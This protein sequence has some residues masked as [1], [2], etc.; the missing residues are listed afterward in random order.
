MKKP[1]INHKTAQIIEVVS[2]VVMCLALFL[3]KPLDL[4]ETLLGTTIFLCLVTFGVAAVVF[5]RCPHC[6][7]MLGRSAFLWDD[8]CP[9]CGALLAAGTETPVRV[10]EKAP[11]KVNLT[12]YVG[13]KRPDGYHQVETVMTGVALCDTVTL[14]RGDSAWDR[15]LC[16]QPVTEREEDN[17]CMKALRVFFQET[18]VAR[19]DFVTISLEKHI[20]T[21]AGLGGGSSDAAAVLRGLRQM[22]APALRDE[23]LEQMAALLGSDVPYFIRGG[24]VL[25]TGRGEQL[26][27][28]P[29]M[30]DCW[31]VIVKPEES[32]ATADMYAAIDSA[33]LQSTGSSRRMLDALAAGE[34]RHIAAEIHNDFQQVLPAGSAVPSI[35]DAL[36]EQGALN[37]QMTGSGSAVF[38]IFQ[39][40]EEAEQAASA[41]RETY[42][43]TICA[44]QV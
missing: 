18:D 5:D 24:T 15:L 29:H 10:E 9:K 41:L 33:D 20:P 4:D 17:L 11:A 21:Q 30:P 38:G 34:L 28:L 42:P 13:E 31:Y 37:A 32:Y 43:G 16:D 25:A 22:Y 2:V 23:E 19:V 3:T 6:G 12:L 26:T 1:L 39:C 35:V 8:R 36:L 40:R 14:T 44:G 7:R 27:P